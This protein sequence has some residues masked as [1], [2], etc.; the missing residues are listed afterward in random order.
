[1]KISGED[2]VIILKY[3][4]LQILAKFKST[5]AYEKLGKQFMNGEV[6]E[7]MGFKLIEVKGKYI[8]II[9]IIF[10]Y[11]AQIQICSMR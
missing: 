9:I 4:D 7:I 6:K 3:S 10:I 1:L 11:K 2:N 5:D 8:I